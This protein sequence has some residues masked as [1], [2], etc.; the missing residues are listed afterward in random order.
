M[1]QSRWLGTLLVLV[2]AGSL[3]GGAAP[4][5]IEFFENK[6]RPVLSK[7]CYECHS[8]QAK[9]VKGDLWLDTREGLLKGGA[10]GPALQPGKAKESLLV[11]AL[12]HDGETKMPPRA[13]KLSKEII[14]DFVK[15]IDMGAPDPRV[16]KTAAARRVIDIDQARTFWSFRPL[17]QAAPPQVK[18]QAWP[19]TPVDRFILARLEEKKLAPNAML[20]R[21][22]LLRRA[23]FDLHGLPPTPADVETFVKDTAPGAYDRL[24]DRLLQ[25]EHVGERWARH[26]LDTVRFAESGGYEFDGD[27]PAAFHYRDFVIRALNQDMPFDQFLR[28]Q[29]AGDQLRPEHL[30]AIAATGFL[31]A[32]SYPGQTTAKTLQLIRYDHL[33]DMVSTLGT[34]MLGLSLGCARCHEHKYDPIPQED[35]YRL[36]ATLGRTDSANL[37]VNPEPEAFKKLKTAFDVAHAPLVVARDRFIATEFA[38]R[39]ESWRQANQD[40]TSPHWLLLGPVDSKAKAALKTQADDSLLASGKPA[41]NDAYTIVLH[42]LQRNLKALRIEALAD[43]ALPKNGP[44]TG[45]DGNFLLTEVN[46]VASPLDA[47]LK[48]KTMPV[49]LRAARTTFE[50]PKLTLAGTLDK[51]KKTGWSVGKQAGKDQAAVFEIDDAVGFE[52]GTVLTLTLK[53]EDDFAIG[54]VRV[55][56]STSAHPAQLNGSADSQHASELLAPVAPTGPEQRA[57]LVRWLRKFDKQLDDVHRTV[58]QH[59]EKEPRPKLVDVFAAQSGRGGDVHFLIRGEVE[60]KREVAQAG[61]VQVLM[62]HVSRDQRW[63]L[64]APLAKDTKA[65]ATKGAAVEPRIALANWLTDVEHGAGRLVARVIVNRLWQHHAE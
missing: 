21:E 10:S 56:L 14:A 17:A 65:P 64:P 26:W 62:N 47:K 50:D 8:A 33:D 42:T 45:A 60:K 16:G 1:L 37:K 11:K 49:K 41:K 24:I 7:Y 43:K 12:E 9:K 3:R 54:R 57:A 39:L 38:R 15:W 55:A 58:E 25:S 28:W 5:G 61:F 32:G 2:A 63:L 4:K 52:G 18:N 19:R 36:V 29:I 48:T 6:I 53:F 59:A 40:K 34:S 22:R 44:G 20:G 13:P 35:Y 31:V 30:E 51:D 46:L 23:T 27:R